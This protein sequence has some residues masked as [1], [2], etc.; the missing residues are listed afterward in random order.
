MPPMILT[1]E[2]QRPL[3]SKEMQTYWN[4]VEDRVLLCYIKHTNLLRLINLMKNQDISFV[5]K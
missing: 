4:N 3:F 1:M 2:K 5:L